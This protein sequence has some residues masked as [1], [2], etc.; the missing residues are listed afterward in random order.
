MKNHTFRNITGAFA[1]IWLGTAPLNAQINITQADMPSLGQT[2]V[3]ATDSS[4]TYTPGPSGAGKF[5]NFDSLKDASND[6][7]R[8]VTPGAT[9]YDSLYS[10]QSPN[11][12]LTYS[13]GNLLFS[14]LVLNSSS[15]TT[16][17]VVENSNVGLLKLHFE[18]PY[19]LYTFPTTY[20]TNWGGVYKY[21]YQFPDT[22]AGSDSARIFEYVKYNDT[23][24]SYG[25]IKT[26][27]D[28][29]ACLRQ[30]HFEMDLDSLFLQNK[31]TQKWKFDR[32]LHNGS[33][34][35]NWIADSIGYPLLT[36]YVDS[37]GKSLYS[38]WLK[39]PSYAGINEIVNSSSSIVYPNPATNE[40][41]IVNKVASTGYV[42]VMDIT[43]RE[44]CKS[45]YSGTTIQLNTAE[46]SNGVYFYLLSD[47]AGN[48]I[49]KGK[50][51]IVK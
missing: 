44:L 50:F 9:K 46:L 22:N 19:T 8:A 17:G 28:S 47:K 37:T 33:N 29:V 4:I 2:F 35:Y 36:M 21:G 14:Y 10:K 25:S 51:S 31:K 32:A 3:V 49:D 11:I 16:I 41:T 43:G 15:M 23:I 7:I 12:A 30:V 5:W 45:A 13:L 26:Q 24:D 39:R 38:S 48:Q 20:L 42:A 40:L 34:S 18:P 27:Y 1:L 6:T